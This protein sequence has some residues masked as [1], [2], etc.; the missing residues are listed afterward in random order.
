MDSVCGE[1]LL[2]YIIKEITN[3]DIKC[4][5]C[6]LNDLTWFIDKVGDLFNELECSRC[7]FTIE[8]N[9]VTINGCRG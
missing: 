1:V 2:R 4:P 5:V 6:M 8:I 3:R 7:G 9:A